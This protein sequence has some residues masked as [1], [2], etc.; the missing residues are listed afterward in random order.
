MTG[1]SPT[2][3]ICFPHH[4]PRLVDSAVTPDQVDRVTSY[5]V[6]D[7]KKASC[8]MGCGRSGNFF[9]I[10]WQW[11]TRIVVEC[12]TAH[13]TI[14]M[15]KPAKPAWVFRTSFC[16]GICDHYG[17]MFEVS[18]SWFR[19][20]QGHPNTIVKFVFSTCPAISDMQPSWAVHTWCNTRLGSFWST[21]LT[22]T[23]IGPLRI[24]FLRTFDIMKHG[25]W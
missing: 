4:W 25:S 18:L 21:S 14:M 20:I 7:L 24:L 15:A 11:K 23:V 5:S 9:E 22:D 8:G 13:R 17:S 3:W 1:S 12:R 19:W 10:R 6:D 16:S 2:S